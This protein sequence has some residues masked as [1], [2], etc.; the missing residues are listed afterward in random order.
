MGTVSAVARNCS[1]QRLRL[2]ANE[3]DAQFAPLM[4]EAPSSMASL[5]KHLPWIEVII[6]F[7]ATTCAYGAA[8]G[9]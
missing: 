7:D 2:L 8:Q 5:L 6:E 4:L 1:R 3:G 9:G